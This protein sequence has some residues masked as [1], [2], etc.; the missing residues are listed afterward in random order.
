MFVRTHTVKSISYLSLVENVWNP[1]TKSYRQ[2]RIVS[3]GKTTEVTATNRI[4]K[5][6]T[7]LTSFCAIHRIPAIADG[8]VLSNLSSREDL[9]S[10]V[11]SFGVHRLAEHVLSRLGILPTLTKL[12]ERFTANVSL[13]SLIVAATA[14]VAHR[15][16]NRSDASE[17]STHA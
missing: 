3:L 4:G 13:P 11:Q 5:I 6:V 17:R 15:L 16:T 9:L 7:A 10:S 12:H 8:I 1:F 2:K 14:L